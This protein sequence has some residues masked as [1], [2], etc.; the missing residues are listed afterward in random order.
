[1]CSADEQQDLGE[2]ILRSCLQRNEKGA[3][4]PLWSGVAG[5]RT[6][7][8][9]RFFNYSPSAVHNWL[10]FGPWTSVNTFPDRPS[11][12]RVPNIPITRMFSSGILN[13]ARH[14]A[15]CGTW[16]HGLRGSRLSSEGEVVA[17][18]F[19]NYLFAGIVNVISLHPRLA[20]T[21]ATTTVETDQ[22]H[23]WLSTIPIGQ[24]QCAVQ[25]YA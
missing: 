23:I 3:T 15:R 21:E 19:G 2:I 17:R 4:R 13:D 25:K 20:S 16:A 7:V 14:Q 24:S 22:P 6:Q 10:F 5:N 1:M 18:I 8:R 12:L 9:R 11:Y